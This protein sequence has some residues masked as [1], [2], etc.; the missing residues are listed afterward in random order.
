MYG[1]NRKKL[2]VNYLWEL[3]GYIW[4]PLFFIS[5]QYVHYQKHGNV[6]KVRKTEN[7]LSSLI[8][9]NSIYSVNQVG[10]KDKHIDR[11]IDKDME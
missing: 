9:T 10:W 5:A 6:M 4:L 2:H 11:P 7:L 8:M 1:N 3:K